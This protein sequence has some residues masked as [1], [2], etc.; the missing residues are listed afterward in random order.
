MHVF[1]KLR[2]GAWRL[3]LV[4]ALCLPNIGS[5]KQQPQSAPNFTLPSMGG[6]NIRLSEY[7]G[8][9][10]LVNFWASWCGP[11]RQEMPLLDKMY[12]R[13]KKAGFTLLGVNVEKDSSKGQRIAEQLKLSFPVLFDKKQQVV[14]DYKVSSMPSTVLV[15]RDGNIRYV[16]LGY[17]AGD[18]KLYSKMVKELLIE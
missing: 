14:D 1:T 11:C 18:E 5:T 4:M 3:L 13:Y 12:Q 16:H 8:E 7:R 2:S 17:K 6:S 15:D 9:V 10:V